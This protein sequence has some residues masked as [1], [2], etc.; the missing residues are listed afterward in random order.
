MFENLKS[1]KKPEQVEFWSQCA[2]YNLK[3]LK[4]FSAEPLSKANRKFKKLNDK[5]RFF[6]LCAGIVDNVSYHAKDAKTEDERSGH[7]TQFQELSSF[8]YSSKNDAHFRHILNHFSCKDSKRIKRT[9]Y[10]LIEYGYADYN[11]PLTL[12]QVALQKCHAFRK[13]TA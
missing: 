8:L 2:W 10:D 9:I 6:F 7:R 13:L 12:V 5:Q 11:D 4:Q 3:Y 1:K